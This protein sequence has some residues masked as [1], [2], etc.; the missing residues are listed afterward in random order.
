MGEFACLYLR[1]GRFERALA[2]GRQSLPLVQGFDTGRIEAV[3]RD[4]LAA[5]CN[6]LGRHHDALCQSRIGL[7][8]R[9]RARDTLGEVGALL[10]VAVA[11]QGLGDD[12]QAIAICEEIIS[13]GRTVGSYE[14]MVADPLCTMAVSLHRVGRD[15]DAHRC[16]AEAAALFDEFGRSWHARQARANIVN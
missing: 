16:W 10:Q 15:E 5:A 4:A 3:V 8:L 12:R 1:R 2:C 14:Y 6:G 7:E 9:V 13:R 11:W